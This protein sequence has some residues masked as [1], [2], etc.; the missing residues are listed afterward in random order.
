MTVYCVFKEGV[1]RHEC[2][3][4]FSTLELAEEAA[5]QLAKGDRDLWHEYIVVPFELDALTPQA[6]VDRSK[7]KCRR[8]P[9]THNY[10]S[11]IPGEYY[12]KGGDLTE[13]PAVSTFQRAKGEEPSFKE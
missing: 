5:N 8:N 1:Y 10:D 7:Q 13:P 11:P 12:G 9:E 4:V 6:Q 3:G 2:G